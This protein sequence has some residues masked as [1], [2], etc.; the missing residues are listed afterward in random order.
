MDLVVDN[1]GISDDISEEDKRLQQEVQNVLDHLGDLGDEV[2]D[3]NTNDDIIEHSYG[4]DG[5]TTTV[6]VNEN[7]DSEKTLADKIKEYY[8]V[9]EDEDK[10]E[11]GGPTK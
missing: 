2:T 3:I 4:E 10:I 7:N 11:Q 1:V 8:G 6:E 5:S 9:F